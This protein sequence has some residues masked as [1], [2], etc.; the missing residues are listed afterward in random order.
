MDDTRG[1]IGRAQFDA[2]K[3]SAFVVDI[4]RGD[5]VITNALVDARQSGSIAWI[6]PNLIVTPHSAD[7]PTM[8]RPLPTRRVFD[9]TRAFLGG[10]GV[11]GVVDPVVGYWWR[12]MS[13]TKASPNR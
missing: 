2:M 8:T 10:G 7:A 4:G 1:L 3:N 11:D 6:A 9:I 12:S 5:L 13:V